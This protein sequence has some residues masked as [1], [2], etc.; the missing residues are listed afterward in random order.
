M[1]DGWEDVPVPKG[2]FISWGDTP[3]QSVIGKVLSYDEQ[4]GTDFAGKECPQ[5]DI[6]LVDDAY[7]VNKLGERFDYPA[8]ELVTL[9]AGLVNLKRALRSAEPRAGD[10]I[11]ITFASTFK[12]K[13][14]TAKLFDVKMKRG[15]AVTSSAAAV[16]D[17]PPF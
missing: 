10:L 14:G 2:A 17:E 13:N 7:S 9:N 8:G 4:G 11:K 6:E 16:D 3:G 12:S 1:T 5:I 15:A